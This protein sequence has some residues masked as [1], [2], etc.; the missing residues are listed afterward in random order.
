VK[1]LDGAIEVESK[2]GEGT[3]FKIVLPITV[4]D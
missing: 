4:G 3:T 2:Y 1:M